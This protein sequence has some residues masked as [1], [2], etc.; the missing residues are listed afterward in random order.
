MG[1]LRG[2]RAYIRSSEYILFEILPGY[3]QF[4]LKFTWRTVTKE[5]KAKSLNR[6]QRFF[7][8]LGMYCFVCQKRVLKNTHDTMEC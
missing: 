2:E 7:K 3:F 1:P 5:L 6:K 8:F 4:Y